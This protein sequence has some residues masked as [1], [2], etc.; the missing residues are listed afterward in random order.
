LTIPPISINQVQSQAQSG[1]VTETY[2]AFGTYC[3][4]FLSVMMHPSSVKVSMMRSNNP[5][6]HHA[7]DWKA[8]VPCII[9]D[10]HRKTKSNIANLS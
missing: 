4:A 8:T 6:I 10:T 1:G 2:K 9:R 7:I 5:R 3:K